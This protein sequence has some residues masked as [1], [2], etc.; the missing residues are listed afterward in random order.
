VRATLQGMDVG[1]ELL[2]KPRSGI[3][4]ADPTSKEA[5]LDVARRVRACVADCVCVWMGVGGW[6]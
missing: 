1:M 6:V 3:V 2:S 5:A 4:P